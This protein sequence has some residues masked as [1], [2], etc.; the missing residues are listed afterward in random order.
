MRLTTKAAH[1]QSE[2]QPMFTSVLSSLT[3]SIPMQL[4]MCFVDQVQLRRVSTLGIVFL[5]LRTLACVYMHAFSSLLHSGRTDATLR[6][7]LNQ[8][9][10]DFSGLATSCLRTA[11]Q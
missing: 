6:S 8:R 3:L 9:T 10:Y 2:D 11:L 7:S 5:V 1:M 4:Q